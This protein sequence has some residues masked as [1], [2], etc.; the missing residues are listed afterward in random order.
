MDVLSL[1]DGISCGRIALE[2]ANIK[3]D[4]YYA[5][6]IDKYAIQITKKNYPDTIHIGDV[7]N[8]DFNEYIGKIDLLIGGSPCFEPGTLVLTFNGYKN[9]E[10]IKIGDTVLT[11]MNRFKNVVTLMKNYIE[12][13]YE[14]KIMGIE[15][16]KTTAEHPFYTRTRLLNNNKKT[17]SV[18]EW[19][20]VCELNKST[21]IGIAINDNSE[22]PK[23]EGISYTVNQSTKGIKNEL[24]Y[25]FN[26]KNFWWTI[27][28]YMGDGWTSKHKRL[29]RKNSYIYKTIICCGKHELELLKQGIGDVFSYCIS[30][31]KTTY[32]IQITN[33]ELF[34]YL[35]Q[36]G[37]GASNKHLTNDIFNLPIEYLES[38]IN[39]YISAD[40][41]YFKEKDKYR[42]CTTSK[43]LAYGIGRCIN[44]AWHTHYS[45]Y[46]IHNSK[47]Y[48]I[49]N[50]IVNQKN[51][52]QIDFY[53][54]N[55]KKQYFYENGYLWVPFRNKILI[56]Y[57]NYVYNM[58][59]EDD[60]SYT[61]YNAIVHNCQ[62]FSKAGKGL[63]FDD[64]RSKLFFKFVEA[65]N[66]I[67]PK[68][69]LL[70]N[71]RMKKEWVSIIS[72]YLKVEPIHINS[73]LVS[74]QSRNRLYWTNIPNVQQPKDKN[75]I[76]QDILEEGI[77]IRQKS[78][79]VR[80]GGRLSNDRH[81][82]DLANI[83]GR[84]Y[85]TLECERLQTLPDNYTEG[86]P[87]KQRYKCIGNCWTVDVIN[88][89]FKNIVQQNNIIN[90]EQKLCI[91]Y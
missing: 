62:G 35:Q 57:N 67:K 58:E 88:H 72:E 41:C 87:E 20:K 27:G 6:E 17:W 4:T 26:D 31:E 10:N 29:N 11:H 34:E 3:V 90:N 44:K 81:E 79:T 68:Y 77:A 14:I 89:I 47:K 63:N 38:F 64:P 46:K 54:N 32:K 30:E 52:Y 28:R 33:Q 70:E 55:N 66:I 74:A 12:N 61:V 59:V 40:G 15:K 39:G 56:N 86:I 9:I 80:V 2:R 76:L 1:F 45:L 8:I 23:W 22:L 85:S 36:F 73:Y 7:N 60:N 51:Y 82:W 19:K 49:E 71:V 5:S 13:L 83:D 25:K 69:F 43:N 84:R 37:N 16:F 42:I 53:I 24:K 75:I 50:R 48:V 65:L 91:N 18:P 78:K 21:Y